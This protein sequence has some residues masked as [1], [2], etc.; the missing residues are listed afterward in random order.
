[1]KLVEEAGFPPGVVN[2]VTGFG[3]PVGD[4]LTSHPLVRRVA[5]TGGSESARHIVRNS[6]QNFAQVSLELGGNHRISCLR[7]LIRIMPR[8]ES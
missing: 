5:F 1:M 7:M 8:W 4:T 6:A 3:M 2:V